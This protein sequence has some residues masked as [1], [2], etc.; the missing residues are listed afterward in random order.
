M[1]DEATTEAPKAPQVSEREKLKAA[2]NAE[3]EA[4]SKAVLQQINEICEKN[5]CRFVATP[6]LVESPNGGWIVAAK[7]GVIAL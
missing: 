1:A 5:N 3:Q 6:L 2:I 4:R 7:P